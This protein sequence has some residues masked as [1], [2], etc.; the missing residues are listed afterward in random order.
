MEDIDLSWGLLART[1]LQGIIPNDITLQVCVCLCL[2]KCMCACLG[3][4]DPVRKDQAF[5]IIGID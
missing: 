5:G 2:S 3:S 4:L 1:V